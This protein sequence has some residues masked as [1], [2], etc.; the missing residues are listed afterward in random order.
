MP[1]HDLNATQLARANHIIRTYEQR[2]FPSGRSLLNR[3]QLYT[4][5]LLSALIGDLE[6]YAVHHDLDFTEIVD[7]GCSHAAA[8]Q[9][10]YKIGDEVRLPRQGDRCGTIVGWTNS[11]SAT[12]TTFL[13]EVPWHHPRPRRARC[14]LGNSATV[15]AHRH[16][17]GHRPIR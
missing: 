9:S 2:A 13:V 7:S 17:P 1:D 10:G 4:R 6:H 3:D 11:R 15:P 12:E 16:P 5:A 14:T 8:R